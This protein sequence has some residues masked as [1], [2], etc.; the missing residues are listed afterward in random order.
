MTR[1]SF[2]SHAGVAAA[3]LLCGFAP[4]RAQAAAAP[5]QRLPP[6]PPLPAPKQSGLLSANGARIFFAQFGQGEPLLFLHGGL[7][8]SDYWGHQVARFATSH[9]VTVMDTRGH[10]RSPFVPGKFGYALFAADV[11]ALMDTLGLSSAAVIGWSDG[12]VTGFHL[13]MTRPERVSKLFAFGGN[14]TPAGLK[15]GGAASPVFAAYAARCRTEYIKLSPYPERWPELTAH[16]RAMWRAEPHFGQDA[17]AAI[18]VPVTVSQGQH[19]EIVRL[20]HSEQL[21]AAIPGARLAL[22]P[23]VSHF[24]MLQDPASFNAALDEFLVA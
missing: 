6:T 7:G 16:L 21:A 2:L 8:N 13:A 4:K 24:A 19:D 14:A 9:L 20:V 3:S 15:P 23:A 17:L 1:R 12:A 10:G 18:R 22:L 11:E 5:W